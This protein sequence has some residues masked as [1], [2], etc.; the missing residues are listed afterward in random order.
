[1]VEG[2]SGEESVLGCVVEKDE[3]ACL[4]VGGRMRDVRVELGTVAILC[5]VYHTAT[6]HGA[7]GRRW[8]YL[9][10][11]RMVMNI[12]PLGHVVWSIYAYVWTAS[13]DAVYA[14]TFYV[15]LVYAFMHLVNISLRSLSA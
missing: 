12:E 7:C 13:M 5:C 3:E 4:F 8:K 15:Q 11:S 2:S 6:S 10:K 1:M 9:K 14:I